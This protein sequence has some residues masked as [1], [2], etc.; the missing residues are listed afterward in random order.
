MYIC[1]MCVCVCVLRAVPRGQKALFLAIVTWFS[2]QLRNLF[3]SICQVLKIFCICIPFSSWWASLVCV[4]QKL[5]TDVEIWD[6]ILWIAILQNQLSSW[7][8]LESVS[9]ICFQGKVITDIP[10]L[11]G[12]EFVVSKNK[13]KIL[14]S[15]NCL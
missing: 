15:I 14:T 7:Q 8:L 13:T 2:Y 4:V 9:L 12:S 11:E 6:Q 1:V 10:T 5:H 3:I